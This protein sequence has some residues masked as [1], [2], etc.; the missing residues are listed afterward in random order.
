MRLN[1]GY[2]LILVLNRYIFANKLIPGPEMKLKMK[3]FIKE[4]RGSNALAKTIQ[5]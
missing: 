5:E 3:D 1:R 4:L 2:E